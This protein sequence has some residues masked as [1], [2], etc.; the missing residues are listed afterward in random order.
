MRQIPKNLKA[1]LD[2]GY[3]SVEKEYPEVKV[4]KPIRSQRNHHLTP[5]AKA[6]NQVKSRARLPVEHLLAKLE[7]FKILSGEFRARLC[8][9]NST[10]TL[11]AGLINFKALGRLA[12]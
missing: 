4:E 7:K 10:F 8:G 2:R 3:E 9:Y 5:L 11:V 12:W 1:R 6:W